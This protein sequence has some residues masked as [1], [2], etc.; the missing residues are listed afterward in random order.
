MVMNRRYDL[1]NHDEIKEAIADRNQDARDNGDDYGS[2]AHI[3]DLMGHF[4]PHVRAH[5]T[6]H[7]I[8]D[9]EE[10]DPAGDSYDGPTEDGALHAFANHDYGTHSFKSDI[11]K[12]DEGHIGKLLDK[13]HENATNTYHG[14]DGDYHVG[15]EFHHALIEHALE[16]DSK[17]L[18]TKVLKHLEDHDTNPSYYADMQNEHGEIYDQHHPALHT[19]DPRLIHR[20]I[21]L[22]HEKGEDLDINNDYRNKGRVGRDVAEH[23]G[24]HGDEKLIS[25]MSKHGMFHEDNDDGM[26][27]GHFIDGLE[28]NRNSENI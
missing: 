28:N 15:K 24:Q 7:G 27:I 26:S 22:V 3:A 5:M 19:T 11:S 21:K 9:H 16:S 13:F 17:P 14:G 10:R 12:M 18:F 20:S 6:V 23:V 8:V 2:H 25:E 1:T 4:P